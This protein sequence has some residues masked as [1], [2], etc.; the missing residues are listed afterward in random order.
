MSEE[1]YQREQKAEEYRQYED[2]ISLIDLALV[3]MRRKWAALGVF[4]VCA[5]F[6]TVYALMQPLQYEY[7]T[8]VELARVHSGSWPLE[9][10]E[11]NQEYSLVSSQKD[12]IDLLQKGIIPDKRKSVLDDKNFAMQ[13]RA[14]KGQKDDK[15]QLVT[16]GH[17]KHEKKI[18]ALHKKIVEAF[19]QMQTQV[20]ERELVSRIAPLQ[21][22][23]DL[24]QE[25][26]ATLQEQLKVLKNYPQEGD[27]ISELFLATRIADL[28]RELAQSRLDKS[29]A[30]S[31][32]HIVRESSHGT[33]IDY[34]A[35]ESENPVGTSRQLIVALSLVL[36]LMLGVFAAFF[37]E[38]AAKARQVAK[39]QQYLH[40]NDD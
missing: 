3:L 16:V 2:E 17:P 31:A 1:R 19:K 34:L 30:E 39:N 36:G 21:A 12:S 37:V 38:F 5:A 10:T 33:Q 18:E 28:R 24:L 6:G 22:R 32:M 40:R 27:S 23:L 7:R 15:L 20:L 14:T 4:L 25:N 26:I 8:G 35:V 9:H 29:D 13:V 11:S